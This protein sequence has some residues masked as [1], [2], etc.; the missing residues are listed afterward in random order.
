MEPFKGPCV[1]RKPV[2]VYLTK[3][4]K[5]ILER[6]CHKLGMDESE[7]LRMAFMNYAE[8]LSLIKE[9]VHGKI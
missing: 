7:V 6:I 5:Q 4:Q 2:K 3:E 8:K 9:K 1:A